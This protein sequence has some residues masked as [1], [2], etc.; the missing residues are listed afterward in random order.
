MDEER[1][2]GP[3]RELADRSGVSVASIKYYLREG[4]LEP[5]T[6]TGVTSARYDERH[7]ERL[8]LIRVLREVGDVPVA[9]I[10]GVVRAVQDRDLSL[11]EVLCTAHDALGPEP[12]A[13]AGDARAGARREVLEHLRAAG[14]NI[15]DGAPALDALAGALLGVRSLIDPAIGPAIFDR[16]LTSAFELASFELDSISAER[17][18]DSAVRQ[19]IVGTIVFEEALVAL[20]RLAEQHHSR[21]RFAV[22][23]QS[24]EQAAR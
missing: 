2:Q 11:N 23:D 16:H 14:W 8:R 12:P 20:R 3:M 18:R 22:Q 13:D 5:G 21:R 19:I 17:G 9:R 1:W 15:S 6:A 24:G 10:A 7:V 4:L